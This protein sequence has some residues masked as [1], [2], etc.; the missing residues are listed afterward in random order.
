MAEETTSGVRIFPTHAGPGG[1]T[2]APVTVV[3]PEATAPKTVPTVVATPAPHT[4]GPGP[5]LG[6]HP[7][8]ATDGSTLPVA[9]RPTHQGEVPRSGR[10]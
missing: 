10:A 7:T 3:E 4:P 9:L 8:P 5:Y 6:V 1:H 2:P